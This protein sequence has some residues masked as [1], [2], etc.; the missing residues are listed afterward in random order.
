MK[1]IMKLNTMK[2]QFLIGNVY[3]LY[4]KARRCILITCQFLIGN[5][6]QEKKHTYIRKL[7]VSIPYR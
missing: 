7:N 1:H 2:C 4:G 5:V 3:Q 6:Y